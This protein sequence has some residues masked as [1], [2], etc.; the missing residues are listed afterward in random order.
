MTE[1]QAGMQAISAIR[2]QRRPKYGNDMV[3]PWPTLGSMVMV[4][5]PKFPSAAVAIVSETKPESYVI[6]A[7]VMDPS[8]RVTVLAGVGWNQGGPGPR[9][10]WPTFTPMQFTRA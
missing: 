9:W 7:H 1:P 5:T 6:T 8:G 10:D 3:V 2:Q 4:Y